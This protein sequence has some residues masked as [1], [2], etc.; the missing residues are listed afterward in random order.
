VRHEGEIIRSDFDYERGVFVVWV[1]H[2]KGG[3]TYI[4][5]WISICEDSETYGDEIPFIREFTMEEIK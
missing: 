2:E 4:S 3:R 1:R 5:R